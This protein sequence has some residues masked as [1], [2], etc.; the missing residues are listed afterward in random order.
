M[1]EMVRQSLQ[2][3]IGGSREEKIRELM[4][5]CWKQRYTVNRELEVSQVEWFRGNEEEGSTSGGDGKAAEAVTPE[6]LQVACGSSAEARLVDDL[7]QRTA[8]SGD[9]EESGLDD[10]IAAST[11]PARH[12]FFP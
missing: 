12:L 7:S 2:V 5:R 3:R 10:S 9:Q 4:S 1:L 11:M 6:F 8:R